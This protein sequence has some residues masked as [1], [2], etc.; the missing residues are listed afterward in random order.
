MSWWSGTPDPANQTWEQITAPTGS[1]WQD[2]KNFI[3]NAFLGT[4]SPE[5]TAAIDS[6]SIAGIN[7]A[8]AGNSDLA[9]SEIA[10]YQ[11]DVNAAVYS[12]LP[13]GIDSYISQ[14]EKYLPWVAG[15]LIL[16]YFGPL[17]RSLGK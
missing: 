9:A 16:F 8:A 12:S 17:I 5:Q 14:F 2:A 13:A 6:D 4:L 10:Q 1:L 7:Q 11:N 15:G 3:D